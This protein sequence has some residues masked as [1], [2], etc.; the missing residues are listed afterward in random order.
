MGA[1]NA[2]P[3]LRWSE[4]SKV[5]VQQI[6]ECISALTPVILRSDTTVTN[7][8]YVN[9]VAN[10]PPVRATG[11]NGSAHRCLWRPAGSMLL[12]ESPYPATSGVDDAHLLGHGVARFQAD[13]DHR[14]PG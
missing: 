6:G 8:G 4:A 10:P 2:D 5:S 3:T 9:G 11:R 12:R 13:Q 7:H 14:H 1:L